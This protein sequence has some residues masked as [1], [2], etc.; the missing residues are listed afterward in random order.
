MTTQE[1]VLLGL[2]ASIV[3]SVFGVGLQASVQ[4]FTYLFRHPGRL[5]RSLFA[6]DVAMPLFALA[7]V[8]LMP[9]PVPVKI[10][11]VALSVS[12][13][14]PMIPK[15]AAKA[16]G[17]DDYMIGLLVAAAIVAVPFVPLA[18]SLLGSIFGNDAHVKLSTI[19]VLMATTVL[20]PLA[21]GIAIRAL[22][23]HV[24][25]RLSKRVPVLSVILLVLALL[26]ILITAWPLVVSQVGDG[27]ILAFAAFIVF[28]LA[29]GH[30]LGG[31]DS[32]DR[33]VLAI[34]TASRHPGVAIAIATESFP[35]QKLAS[36]AIILYLLV[37]VVLTTIY[38]QWRA[39]RHASTG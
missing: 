6:M 8:A 2:K 22:S 13:V 26:P 10:A 29:V 12:P 17:T 21:A 34:A 31:P 5:A 27:A 15:K 20:V 35:D 14:P 19:A 9:L 16:G 38:A 23:P 30:I 37:S 24:A 4:Q 25:D 39:R 7:V 33:T 1:I 28:G 36:A 11:L 3:L 32:G 18:V